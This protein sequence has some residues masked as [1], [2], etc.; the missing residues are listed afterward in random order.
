MKPFDDTTVFT[1]R[2]LLTALGPQHAIEMADVLA[3]ERL[4]EFIGGHPASEAELR[5][6]YQKYAAGSPTSDETWLNWIVRRRSD[7]QALGTLQATVIDREA[8]RTA[9]VAWV[10]GVPWQNHGYASEAAQALVAWLRG[11]DVDHVVA[12][13]HP[14]HQASAIVAVR[15]GLQPTD[16]QVDGER[17]WRQSERN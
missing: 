10:I 3:G 14:D 7:G 13:I 1:E 9:Y 2:L 16:E 8:A 6:R 12:H 4:H 11:H 15:A 17:V 5:A